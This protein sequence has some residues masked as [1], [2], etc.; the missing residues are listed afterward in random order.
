MAELTLSAGQQAVENRFVQF[1]ADPNEPV[2]VIRGYSGTG[3]STLVHTLLDN[4]PKYIKAMKM[5][6]DQYEV[7]PIQLTATTHKA[8][9][10]FSQITGMDV[11]TI[12]SFLGLRL[13]T[14]YTTGAKTLVPREEGKK[15]NY[16][17]FIDEASYIDQ[18]TLGLIFKQ[19]INCKIVFIGDPAQLLMPRC[20]IAP[21]FMAGFPEAALTET[22]RQLVNGVPQANPI[23]ELATQFR[24]TVETGEWPT[25]VNVDGQ[26]VQWLP[27][28]DFMKAIEAEFT[29]PDWSY[30]S[31]KVLAWTNNCVIDYNKHIRALLKGDPALQVGDYVENNQYVTTGNKAI[32]TDQTV[33]ITDI[34]EIE[35]IHGVLGNWIELDK[36]IRVFHPRDRSQKNKVAAKLRAEGNYAEANKVDNW[37]DLRAVFAQ[38]INKAQGSTYD[39]VYIDLDDIKKCNMGNLIARMLYVG[40]SRARLQVILTGDIV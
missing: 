22:M 19:A 24:H 32:K 16:L 18:Y 6:D 35:S 31:S 15:F 38:T 13:N 34:E 23:T 26:Y 29:R 39:K 8:A 36:V 14:D 7:P 21:A 37:I 5:I 1:L 28:A 10:N 20:S 12:H 25:K 33:L 27:R 4:L 11:S 2:L 9:E 17:I 30:K 40:I 3:K